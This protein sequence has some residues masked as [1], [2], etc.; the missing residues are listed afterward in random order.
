[1][2]QESNQIQAMQRAQLKSNVSTARRK[3][4]ASLNFQQVLRHGAVGTL[5]FAANIVGMASP[6]AANVLNQAASNLSVVTDTAG[7]NAGTIS[8]GSANSAAS[9]LPTSTSGTS[10]YTAAVAD[11]AAGGNSQAQMFMATRELQE[12]NQS[13]NLQYLGLQEDMQAEN[14]KYSALS[15]IM[16]TKHDTAKNA[17][18]NL[19]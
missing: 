14:R 15:N 18:N 1:M 9:G 8:A 7:P 10:N 11:A 2:P 12:L 4:S 5:G 6:G 16:K 17:L 3:E 13:F 19:K